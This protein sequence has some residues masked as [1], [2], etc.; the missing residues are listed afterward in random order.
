[1]ANKG[2]SNIPLF[3]IK[4]LQVWLDFVSGKLGPN[5]VLKSRK[6]RNLS[7]FDLRIPYFAPHVKNDK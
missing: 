5:K 3:D 2:I 7:D 6:L 4:I 1:M